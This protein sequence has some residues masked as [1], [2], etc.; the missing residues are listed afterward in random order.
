MNLS[1]TNEKRHAHD[2]LVAAVERHL[3]D[4]DWL[5]E[6]EP[7]IAG[8]LRPDI[9]ARS[10][11]GSSYVFEIKTGAVQAHLGAVAQVENYRNS[12]AAELG[13]ETTGV[14]VLSG[15]APVQLDAVAERAGVEVVQMSSD[16]EETQY[17]LL[18]SS[19]A[20]LA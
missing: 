14:L 16:A 1:L 6:R 11:K 12:L 7:R 15:S 4:Q 5:V 8:T 18:E 10:P 17:D 2:A 19:L 9:V 3:R 20:A 13:H